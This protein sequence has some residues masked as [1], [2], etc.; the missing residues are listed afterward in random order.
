MSD[1]TRET[2]PIWPIWTRRRMRWFRRHLRSKMATGIIVLIPIYAT[3]VIVKA[4]FSWIDGILAPLVARI[5][6]IEIPGLGLILT[7]LVVYLVGLLATQLFGQ[8]L[9]DGIDRFLSNLPIVKT[10]YGTFKQISQ[11][12]TPAGRQ[13][14]KRVVFVDYPRRGVKVI[15]FVTGSMRT[16][17]GRNLLNVFV[18]TAPN[19]TGGMLVLVPESEVI[20]TSLTV[21]EGMKLVLS[22]GL[23]SPDVIRLDER[24]PR[25]PAAV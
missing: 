11:T 21:E 12:F 25:G 19:P 5:L 10:L 3:V 20:E 9:I 6:R 24:E 17:D 16:E 14:F 4:V 2:E 7:L 15:G 22:S 18:P 13:S 1:D 23:V 8:Q